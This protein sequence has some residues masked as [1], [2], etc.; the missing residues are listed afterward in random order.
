MPTVA[1]VDEGYAGIDALDQLDL[2]KL[3]KNL[4]KKIFHVDVPISEYNKTKRDA[5]KHG[6]CFIS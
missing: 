6:I 5:K 1:V 3:G 4:K 2:K